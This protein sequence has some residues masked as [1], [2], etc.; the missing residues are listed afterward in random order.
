M[1]WAKERKRTLMEKYTYEEFVEEVRRFLLKELDLREKQ[2]YFEAKD[3]NGMTPNGDRLFIECRANASGKEVCGIHIE[4][5]YAD[6]QDGITVDKIG[7]LI[8]KEIEKIKT[9]ELTTF[10]FNDRK[11]KDIQEYDGH[12]Y[13]E[14]YQFGG[15]VVGYDGEKAIID[16]RNRLQVGDTLEI[17]VPDQLEAVQFKIDKLWDFETNE[18]KDVVNPGVKDQ[19]VKMM[20]PVKCE[21]NWIIR[22]KK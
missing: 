11:N 17:L 15:K 9:R 4:E 8:K 21:E 16:I 12:Q 22:R 10:Y 20:L 6:Y 3:E 7:N 18:E 2:I 14:K 5:M 19:K 13:N 1:E